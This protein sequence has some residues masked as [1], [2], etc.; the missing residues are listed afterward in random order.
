VVALSVP[1]AELCNLLRAELAKPIKVPGGSLGRILVF[2]G[3]VSDLSVNATGLAVTFPGAKL[4]VEGPISASG[5]LTTSRRIV[6]R[7]IVDRNIV[8]H[9]DF[10]LEARIAADA[11]AAFPAAESLA[12]QTI[13]VQ[14]DYQQA[15]LQLRGFLGGLPFAA[16]VFRGALQLFGIEDRIK[17]ALPAR[18]TRVLFPQDA[19]NPASVLAKIRKP[20]IQVSDVPDRLQVKASA[21]LDL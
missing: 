14:L 1:K 21:A 12:Q 9:N 3:T 15:Q 7:P 19:S 20:S 11:A 8:N 2:D 10:T 16:D 13:E 18:V 4:H 6:I 17:K 5:N